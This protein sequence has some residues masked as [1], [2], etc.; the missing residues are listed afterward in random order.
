MTWLV[1]GDSVTGT[2]HRARNTPCQDAFRF[3]LVGPAQDFLVIA[4]VDG[5]GS[6]ARSEIGAALT[7]DQFLER[8]QASQPEALLKRD[9]V[10]SLFTDVR[11]ALVEEACKL[12]VPPRELACTAMLCVAD[13]NSAA[14]AQVGDG[15]IVI[16]DGDDYR[17]VFWP[18]PAEY[19]NATDFLTDDGFANVLRFEMIAQPVNE[20][21]AFTDGLQRLALDYAG[22]APFSGFFRP[23]FDSLR[24]AS[25]AESLLAPLRD[26]LDSPRVNARTDDDKTLVLALRRP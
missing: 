13:A 3:G 4:V 24:S 12:A 18:E 11:A 5:A 26:F 8:V 10:L 23:A 14:F 17:T 6:A 22:R 2:S 25:D 9:A 15:A 7:C 1:V 16:R 21:A 19:A 20:V